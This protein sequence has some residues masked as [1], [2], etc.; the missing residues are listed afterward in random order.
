MT[1]KYVTNYEDMGPCY[2]EADETSVRGEFYS[3]EVQEDKQQVIM[4]DNKTKK[5]LTI[6]LCMFY[7]L[8]EMVAILALEDTRMFSAVT[9]EKTSKT[10]TLFQKE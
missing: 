3:L 5:K 1:N 9:I 7:S 6:P 8:P 10:V 4:T 2:Y